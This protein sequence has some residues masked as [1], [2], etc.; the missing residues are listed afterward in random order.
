MVPPSKQAMVERKDDQIKDTV[1]KR[2][3]THE[4]L[5]ND[6]IHVEVQ[7][8]VV[9]LTGKVDTQ[10][11]RLAALTTARTSDGVRSVVG[12]DLRVEHD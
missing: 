8:G 9:R 12:D 11:D 4:G 1:E 7:N 6:K 10:S 5:A 2:L 3:G